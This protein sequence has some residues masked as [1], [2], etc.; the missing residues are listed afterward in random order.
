MSPRRDEQH[1]DRSESLSVE[2]AGPVAQGNVEMTGA[3]VA[4][5]DLTIAGPVNVLADDGAPYGDLLTRPGRPSDLC[6][7]PG[8]DPF[9]TEFAGYF[10]GR[11]VDTTAVLDLLRTAALVAVVGSSGSGKSS[12]LSAGVLP[13]LAH[14][15]IPGAEHWTV[16]SMRPGAQ[17]VERL[18]AVVAESSGA[19]PAEVAAAVRSDPVAFGAFAARVRVT[20]WVVDQLEEVFHP[21]VDDASRSGFLVALSVLARLAGTKVVIALRSDFYPHLDR[22]PELAVAVAAAQHR[23]LPLGPRAIRDVIEKPAD[24]VGLRVEQG[25]VEQILVDVGT[26]ESALPLLSYALEQTWR[27][28]R[29]GWLTLAAY[30]TAGGLNGAID[31]AAEA[32]WESLDER[33]RVTARRVMLRLSHLGEG[34]VPVRRQTRFDDLVT[35]ADDAATVREVVDRLASARVVSVD[36]DAAGVSTVDITHEAV[37]RAWS[38]LRNWLTEDREAKRAQDDLSIGATAWQHHGMDAGY[39]LR[40]ARLAAVEIARRG[41]ALTVNEVELRFLTRSRRV[42]RRQRLR[43]RL[44]GV[45]AVGLAVAVAVT[46]VVVGQQRRI[47]QEKTVADA[48]ALAAQSRSVVPQQRDLG[49]LLAVAGVRTNDNPVTRAAVMDAVASRGGPLAYLLPADRRATTVANSFTPDGSVIVGTGDGA[50]R[51]L[52]PVDGHETAPGLTGHRVNITALASTGELVLSGDATGLVSVHRIG[53]A[54][55]VRQPVMATSAVV[56]ITGGKDQVLAATRFG[57]IE[58]WRLADH[59]VP[60]PPLSRGVDVVDLTV[61]DTLDQVVAI[62]TAGAVLRWRLSDGAELPDLAPAGRLATGTTMRLE[63]LSDNRLVTV[64]ESRVGV[65]DLNGVKPPL[66]TDVSG[67]TAVAPLPGSDVVFVGTSGGT[68]TSWRLAPGPLAVEPVRFGL[69]PPV[70]ALAAG[71]GFLVGVDQ[72][73]RIISWD[74]TGRR[75][76]A[77][78]PIV[79]TRGQVQVVA[80]NS[81]GAVASADTAGLVRLTQ[82]GVTTDAHAFGLPVTGM[83]WTPTGSIIVGTGGGTV[84]ELDPRT[85]TARAILRRSD[86]SIIGLAV[87]TH[88]ALAIAFDD[89]QVVLPDHPGGA[90]P[91]RGAPATSFAMT[92]DGTSLAIAS[93]DGVRGPPVIT[94]LNASDGFLHAHT[95]RGHVLPVSSLAF[96]PDGRFLASGSDDRTIRLWSL[97][98]YQTVTELRGHADMVLAL[99]YTPDGRTLASGSQD[100]T[101]RLWDIER[102]LQL[103]QP[104]RFEDD[105]VWSLSASV[106]GDTLVAANGASVVEWPFAPAAW[107]D[108]ACHLAGREITVDEWSQFRPGTTPQKFCAR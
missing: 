9:G 105:F 99:A 92:A 87:D 45:L 52:S 75:S 16:V 39:L 36:L 38:R 18:A 94:V 40:G 51:V 97:D 72:N 106:D 25:L 15:D 22:E 32:V 3:I 55:P 10:H 26:A 79:E 88:G 93:G 98:D 64:D 13:A 46:L 62:N 14:G 86:A 90:L 85:G 2:N 58:R 42:D 73:G 56:A 65:W 21:A 35:D 48:L 57:A 101:I 33:H 78:T 8:L 69:A 60:L 28:R 91:A 20:V 30:V 41:N 53:A 61:V 17:P 74:L 84:H 89:G 27:R 12:L 4:G 81:A 7:Y 102:G 29:N 5:R 83:A 59:P 1:G 50:I 34:S 104:L 95:L 80:R 66:W 103:G 19:D 70:V 23:L 77:G 82:D 24:T 107:I 68:I 71:P 54:E 44:L 67:G 49:A 47:S 76:P 100:G 63:A 43:S 6:P 11:V 108:R 96:S 31:R 37:L